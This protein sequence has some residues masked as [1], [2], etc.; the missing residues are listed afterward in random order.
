[1]VTSREGG[2][3]R[4][5]LVPFDIGWQD[6][7][8]LVIHTSKGAGISGVVVVEN[9]NNPAILSKLSQISI[10][11]WDQIWHESRGIFEPSLW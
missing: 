1:M 4:S 8:G 2:H 5:D 3:V 6:V 10:G 7:D 11:G 9:T